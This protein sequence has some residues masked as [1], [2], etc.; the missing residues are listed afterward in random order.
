[1]RMARSLLTGKPLKQAVVAQVST[2]CPTRLIAAFCSPS[3]LKPK[4]SRLTPGRPSGVSSAESSRSIP[5][6]ASQPIT[7][8]A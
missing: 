6:S 8:A 4:N 7:E 2:H 1:M 3:R 5:A